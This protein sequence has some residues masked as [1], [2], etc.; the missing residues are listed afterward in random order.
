MMTKPEIIE[1]EYDLKDYKGSFDNEKE[2]AQ[3]MC[4]KMHAEYGDSLTGRR[5]RLIGNLSGRVKL[6]FEMEGVENVKTLFRSGSVHIIESSDP[7]HMMIRISD[8]LTE[9]HMYDEA[10]DESVM[11]FIDFYV[12]LSL[13]LNMDK[14]K[15][16]MKGID[17]NLIP[18]LVFNKK[19]TFELTDELDVW[20][21]GILDQ[22]NYILVEVDEEMSSSE[23]YRKFAEDDIAGREDEMLERISQNKVVKIPIIVFVNPNKEVVWIEFN[24]IELQKP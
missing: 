15:A 24:L 12:Q 10:D 1:I 18:L 17:L 13:T 21:A 22:S 2:L 3:Y 9:E 23:E 20:D 4:D 6:A 11:S 19:G 8:R 16:F 7:I 5:V 14:I